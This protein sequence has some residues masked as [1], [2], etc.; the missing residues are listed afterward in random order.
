MAGWETY[1]EFVLPP[2]ANPNTEA[3]FDIGVGSTVTGYEWVNFAF[4]TENGSWLNEFVISVNNSDA[5]FFMDTTLSD[6]GAPGSFGPAS[7]SWNDVDGFGTG[8]FVVDDG[9][10]WV[11]IY[12]GFD[13][14]GTAVRDAVVTSGTLRVF[15]TP[16]PEPTSGLLLGLALVGTVVSSRRR[17]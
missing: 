14:G 6:V 8:P 16:V 9:V 5:G 15:F 13:D 17:R 10:L 4:T 2:G 3:F 11:T 12:E 1:G 7:G